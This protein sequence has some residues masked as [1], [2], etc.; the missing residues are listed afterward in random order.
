MAEDQ[1]KVV[2]NEFSD[3]LWT[4][5]D[6]V[7]QPKGTHR[8]ALNSVNESKEGQQGFR[9]NERSNYIVSLL[10]DGFFPIGDR[11]IEDDLSVIISV[12]PDTNRELI[13]VITKDD[14]Y[15]TIVDTSL[16]NLKITNQCD[17]QYRLRRGGE[18]VIYWVDE[19]N[20]ARTFNL[21][22]EYNFYNT[23][24]QTYLKAGGDPN[25]FVGEK[26]DKASFDLQ[27]TVSKIPFFANIEITE[28]GA[29]LPGSYNFAIQL[30]D[31]DLNPTDWITTS[32]IARIYNDAI[33]S[34]FPRI[35]GSRNIDTSSQSFPRA[36]KSIRLTITNLDTSFPYYR[37]AIIRAAGNTGN[38][39]K[40]LLS[41]LFP[42]SDSNFIYSGND[43]ELSEGSLADILIDQEIIFAPKHIEQIENRLILSNT[44]GKSINWCEFQKY[45]SKISANLT[46]K[47][48]ILN[49]VL[50]EANIKNAKST[51]MYRGYMP[52]EVYA[53]NAHYVFNDGFISPGFHI[54]GKSSTD[55]T[56]LM[57]VHELTSRYIDVH[58][59]S[60]DNYWGDDANGNSLVGKKVRHHRFPFRKEV[61]K[62]LFTKTS[63][64][65][66][67]NKHR[68]KV[69]ITLNP[70]W[71][72]G[73]IEY[74]QISGD[75]AV[76]PYTIN[77][78]VI[79][80][81]GISV[82]N[83]NLVDTD[84]G[85]DIIIYDDLDALDN[86]VIILY[87]ELDPASDLATI[88]QGGGNDRFILTFTYQ[89]Y[90]ASSSIDSDIS[91]IFGINFS[92]IQKP[93]PDV[94]GVIF[95]RAERT[96]DDR[97]IL[98]N[99]IF[100]PMTEFNQY[101]AFGLIMPKQYYAANN[102]GRVG[103]TN[104]TITYS[105]D[106]VW[107]FNPEFQFLNKKTEFASIE[108]EGKYSEDTVNMPTVSNYDG[109]S[110]NGGP[111]GAFNTSQG[112]K[113]VYIED[114]QAGTSYNPDL[115]KKKDKDDD[116]FDLVVG[117]RNTNVV[118]TTDNSFIF[119]SKKRVMY[120]SAASYQNF[121]TNVFY[122][123]SVD[124]K[125]GMYLSNSAFSTQEFFNT[126]TKKN[127]L[128]YGS[129]VRNN[130]TSYANFITRSYYKE[131]NN[132]FLF[133]PTGTL[134]NIRIFNGD[135]E[136]SGFS[137]VSSVFYDMVVAYRA[138]KNKLWKIIV[139]AVLII[140]A[141]VVSVSTLGAAT[142]A[143][144]AVAAGS[145]ATAAISYGVSLAMSGIK[146][147]Q[148]KSMIDADYE[149][150]L[151]ETVVDGGVFETIRDTIQK[152]DDTIRWFADRVSNL[153]IES[154][155]PFGLRSGLTCG[156]PDFI[157]APGPYDELGFRSYLIE[158][159]T[160]L[161]RDQGSGRMYKGYATAE[162]YDMNLDYMRFNKQ[163]NFIHLPLEY[164]CCSDD[165]EIFPMRNWY[166]EQSFQEEKV[167]N[168]RVF[169]PNNFRDIE[170][171]HGEITDL[172]RLGNSL[173]I[174]TKE[175]LW[176]LPQN[177]QERITNEIVSF[178]GTG[179]FFSIPVR[180]VID[181]NLGSG[182]TQ[183]KWGT[184]KTKNGVLF[185]NEVE[186]HIYLHSDGI[187]NVSILGMRNYFKNNLTS[188]LSKQL[189][190]KYGINFL[191]DNNPANRN[192]IG[193]HSAYDTRYERIIIT[194]RDYLLLPNKLSQL[195]LVDFIPTNG[196]LFVYNQLNGLFYQGA[197]I[198]HLDNIDYFEN[199][200]WTVS[201]SFHNNDK[202]PWESWHS[203]IPNY[204]IYTQNNLYSHIFSNSG[205]W[206]HNRD[207]K[208]QTF[209]ALFRPWIIEF[210]KLSNPLETVIGEDL[211]LHTK[212]QRWDDTTQEFTN[213][214]YVTFNK[215]LVYNNRQNSGELLM[216]IKDTQA[217][218]ENWYL[219]Q[220]VNT[221]GEILITRKEKNWNLNE[222]RDIVT[223]Y[224]KSMFTKDW[225]SIKGNYFI[226]KV[227]NP[228]AV[229]FSKPWEEL[230]NFRDKYIIIRLKFD[231]F[232]SVNLILNYSLQTEQSSER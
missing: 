225:V 171:E 153:Y 1:Y 39:E 196:N 159:L 7:N 185:V 116:G 126:T 203:Y 132:P 47:E 178:I 75:P 14:K 110:C 182:G 10:P 36:N 221:S 186:G 40:V 210:V 134:N 113:G 60:T 81:P 167:D 24:Y 219:Q 209:Y 51:F 13:G 158:K 82:Y 170:G 35:R 16:L 128:K 65:T 32:N 130:N 177:V 41:E 89:T 12:N 143:A 188:F 85:T 224:S 99:A 192:G 80:F 71:T 63:G 59:C 92:N 107:F 183:H 230:Q 131:H 102:C 174:Q 138:K 175:G 172:Y 100:G 49:N 119:P 206:K 150:G 30:I 61:S 199:K 62:P 121:E 160:V 26:W 66:N 6:A 201:Y 231:N 88:Y 122:N 112:S 56:S 103:N 15:R 90:V 57:K 168:Y 229:D 114:V 190:I 220:V 213:E 147:E 223:D 145:L 109:S 25:T 133:P 222:L 162:L 79:G 197:E 34:P 136:I 164:D 50:S 118:Y 154:A 142:P 70:A 18:R 191:N 166:S 31:E 195:I 212:A 53:F 137:F 120:L 149:T 5:G 45:A 8:F 144:V 95:T 184:V 140:T 135:A 43:G 87:G 93:H 86:G 68:L 2:P 179:N 176:H 156:V 28:T 33:T 105:D 74:P 38:P 215:L 146:F 180:K 20:V 29:I 84:I 4:D 44:K 216:K 83:S 218:P 73:P 52:G 151:R 200:S 115:H 141:I 48:V 169:L 193:I 139:G 205:I 64:V 214:E 78:Q 9:S 198:I 77:Y 189:Y 227:L 161:D 42:T 211:T 97:I 124:N 187:K 152:E 125:I 106:G 207:N 23:T 232:D 55:S 101:R 3:G 72:P 27:K 204:Y 173:F 96:E 155:V 194:K 104:K 111:G 58:N 11:Y 202:T 217:N 37:V 228:L 208:F 129:L 108:V 17:I 98:D 46:T 123:V 226:D 91:E 163:K 165:N 76:I 67:I 19:L 117:Y 181:D 127:H 22:R 69:N 148:F 157:D 94:V 21:D 54:P